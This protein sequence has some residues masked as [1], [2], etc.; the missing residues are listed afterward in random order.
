MTSEVQKWNDRYT[1]GEFTDAGPSPLLACAVAEVKPGR[2]LDLACGNGRHA[3]FLAQ[4]GWN[5]TAVDGAP[6]AVELVRSRAAEQNL[7]IDIRLVDLES[8]EFQISLQ[9]WDLI[10]DFYYL[11][12]SLFPQIRSGLAPGGMFVAAIHLHDD[13]PDV[14]PMNPAFLLNA[15][16]L[17]NQ[18]SGWE[19][20]HYSEGAPQDSAHRRRTAEI[21]ARRRPI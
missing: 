6:A 15:G 14:K 4:R 9:R 19:I 10:C 7:Q 18:F 12:W 16:E 21:I 2:A 5:V 11:Q 17:R 8:G 3:V 13:S 1:R 20:L